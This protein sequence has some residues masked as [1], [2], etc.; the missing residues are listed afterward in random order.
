M[1]ALDRGRSRLEHIVFA[2]LKGNNVWFYRWMG[3]LLVLI[4]LGAYAYFIQYRDGLVVTGMRDRVSWGLYIAM[5]VF[6]IAISYG[7]TLTS[8]VL[9][10]TQAKW[11]TPITR[12]AELIT[13]ASL[14]SGNLFVILDL[15]RPDRMQ[16][17]LLFGRWQSPI[18]WDI[19]AITTYLAGSVIY[20]YLPLIPDLARCRDRLAREVPAWKRWFYKMAALGWKDLPLQKRYLNVGMTTMM[21]LIVPVAISVHSVL[22]WIFGMTLREPWD[23]P[24]FGIFFVTGAIFSGVATVILVMAVFRK[25]YHLEEWIHEKH[26]VYLSYLMAALA[27]LMIYF[28]VAEYLTAG[29]KMAG[30]SALHMEE[31]FT[32]DMA[33]LYWFYVMGGLFLPVLIV[34]LPQT[35]KMAGILVAAIFVNIAMWI[36]RY[37][38][39]VGG[40]R[41]PLMPY[42]ARSYAPTWIEWGIMVGVFALFLFILTIFTKLFPVLAIWEVEEHEAEQVHGGEHAHE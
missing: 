2:P 33:G 40:L 3:L 37:I 14:L 1:A 27:A 29:Y 11:R 36:E 5:F 21:V 31:L 24:M 41:L 7:G 42:E 16:N 35:R 28:N 23:N 32:G 17:L 22:S 8:A 18:I 6:V 15:G 25:I 9:R 34:L 13:V 26:F 20:L 12:L 10:A 30:D 39:V 19:T 38:I 4:G